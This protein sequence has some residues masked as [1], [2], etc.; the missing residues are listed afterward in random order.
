MLVYIRSMLPGMSKPGPDLEAA[1]RASTAQ[2]LF[3]CARLVN[4]RAIARV[5]ARSDVPLLKA[6]YTALFP[7]LDFV[8]VRVV[9]LAKKLGISKQAVSQTLAELCNLGVVELVPDPH[10]GRAKRARFT[11]RGGAALADGL[12]VLRGIEAELAAQIGEDRMRALHEAL[13]ALEAALTAE[14]AA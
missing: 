4:E 9:D 13:L 12:A 7:H 11:R 6:S 10:D 3:K 1:K 14:G 5:N 2:L 8:G